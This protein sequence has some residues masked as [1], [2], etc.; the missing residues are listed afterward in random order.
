MAI[1]QQLH[2]RIKAIA[3]ELR[4]EAY[5]ASG[6]PAWG[7]KFTEIED[8]GVEIGDLLAREV[9]GQ[10][11]EDQASSLE[12]PATV[13]GQDGEAGKSELRIVQTRRGEVSWQEPKGYDKPSRKAFFP[14]VAG[15]GDCAG[16]HGESSGAGEDG[17]RR[18]AK[19]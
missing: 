5:G 19:P 7:T 17:V 8:L 15:P 3:Q 1:S 18:D 6:T 14:S 2:T 9:I 12:V 11:L 4:Q 10:S 13:A 16:R